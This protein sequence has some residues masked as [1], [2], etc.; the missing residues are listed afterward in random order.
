MLILSVLS[1]RERREKI[2]EPRAKQEK[3]THRGEVLF[4]EFARGSF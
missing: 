3:G 2:I 4:S 1:T